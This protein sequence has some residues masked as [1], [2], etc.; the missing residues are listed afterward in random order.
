MQET[1]PSTWEEAQTLYLA[2]TTAEV[3]DEFV[4]CATYMYPR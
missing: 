1:G 4:G 2:F 3:P